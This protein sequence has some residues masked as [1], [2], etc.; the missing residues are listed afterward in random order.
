MRLAIFSDLDGC[1]LNKDDY[2]FLAAVPTVERIRRLEIPLIL[3][4]SKTFPEMCGLAS[5]MQLADAPL[6]CE[7]GGIIRWTHCDDSEAASPRPPTRLGVAR[8]QILA[9]LAE[10]KRDFDFRTFEDLGVEG[11]MQATSLPRERARHA[12]QRSCTEPLQWFDAADRIQEFSALLAARKLTLTRGGRFWH[13]AGSTNK[14]LAM[15][16]VVDWLKARW[17]APVATIAIGD[18]PIDQSMLDRADYP[19]GIPAPDGVV[20]VTVQA[21]N[22]LIAQHAGADGWAVSLEQLL[23]RLTG[24]RTDKGFHHPVRTGSFRS[25]R[26]PP[27]IGRK[28]HRLDA[29]TLGGGRGRLCSERCYWDATQSSQ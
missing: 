6:I 12:L 22:G 9:I 10:L 11:V 15:Q 18:S 13:V 23:D 27:G 28:W 16:H 19:V 4:S 5:E 14:G 2:S 24:E 20:Q 8:E 21:Q 29:E 1:L 7:N 17:D 26:I 3:A 25:S